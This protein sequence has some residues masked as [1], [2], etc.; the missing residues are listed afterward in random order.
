ML[1]SESRRELC[2]VILCFTTCN[3]I[4]RS[5]HFSFLLF[6][7]FCLSLS[8]CFNCCCHPMSFLDRQRLNCVFVYWKVRVASLPPLFI[9]S[10]RLCLCLFPASL[11]PPPSVIPFS[12]LSLVG[13]Y[14]IFW[15]GSYSEHIIRNHWAVTP[16]WGL[17][18]YLFGE[19]GL[20]RRREGVACKTSSWSEFDTGLKWWCPTIHLDR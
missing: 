10:L 11:S 7:C 5:P 17:F 19:G 3:S 20:K 13:L 18:S 8:L 9:L 4:C 15:P 16:T 2:I 12:Y 14:E 6:L 1:T